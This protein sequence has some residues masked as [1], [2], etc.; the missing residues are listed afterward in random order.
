MNRG[1]I[2]LTDSEL[3]YLHQLLADS[4]ADELLVNK[5]APTGQDANLVI[6]EEDVELIL[7]VLPIPSQE[8]PETI[9]RIRQKMSVF[10]SSLRN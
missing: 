9:R 5:F 3:K 1:S 8:Q 7:D 2:S 6:S 4:G 10:L